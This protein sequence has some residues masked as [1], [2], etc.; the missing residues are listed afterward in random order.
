MTK[1]TNSTDIKIDRNVPLPPET[2]IIR[3]LR[4]TKY[5]FASLGVGDSFSVP[6]RRPENK[7]GASTAVLL[8]SNIRVRNKRAGAELFVMALETRDDGSEWVRV[9]RNKPNP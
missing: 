2:E 9:W 5:P 7:G 6:N 1:E 3:S 8:R 4:V